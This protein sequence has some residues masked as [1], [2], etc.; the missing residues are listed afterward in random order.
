MISAV[1]GVLVLFCLFGLAVCKTYGGELDHFKRT[2]QYISTA[3]LVLVVGIN[4]ILWLVRLS[5][6]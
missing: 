4:L 2:F 6:G 1:V 5:H 3:C